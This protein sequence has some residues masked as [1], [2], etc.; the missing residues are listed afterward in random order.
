MPKRGVTWPG[1]Q[2]AEVHFSGVPGLYAP[3]R[4]VPLASTGLTEDEMAEV[5]ER[6]GVPLEIVDMPPARKA[7]EK[8]AEAGQDAAEEVK[9]DG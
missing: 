6:T 2:G 5:I 7:K 3:G 4:I 9:R 1:Q 8:P